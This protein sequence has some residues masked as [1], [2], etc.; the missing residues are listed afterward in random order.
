MPLRPCTAMIPVF[1][2]CSAFVQGW[3][4][5]LVSP[6]G[7]YLINSCTRRSLFS[8]SN[9]SSDLYENVETRGSFVTSDSSVNLVAEL[10]GIVE[11]SV[12]DMA[13][14]I[15]DCPVEFPDLVNVCGAR[16]EVASRLS[17]AEVGAALRRRSAR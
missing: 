6:T 2:Y 13:P 11:I 8:S 14:D 12:S 15:E 4:P 17:S 3:H 16:C 1:S 9:Y 7:I 10:E 5:V